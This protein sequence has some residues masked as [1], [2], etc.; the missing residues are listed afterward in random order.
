[1]LVVQGNFKTTAKMY[2]LCDI[3]R[4]LGWSRDIFT[5]LSLVWLL[6]GVLHNLYLV[7][8]LH[9]RWRQIG[10]TKIL[11]LTH[12][13]AS[14]ICIILH[15]YLPVN[16]SFNN[17]NSKQWNF[18]PALCAVLPALSSMTTSVSIITVTCIVLARY[19]KVVYGHKLTVVEAENAMLLSWC[20]GGFLGSPLLGLMRTEWE[21][22]HNVQ[23][24]TARWISNWHGDFYG[25][26][27]IVIQYIFPMVIMAAG[28]MKIF[29]HP[30]VDSRCC[31]VLF[32]VIDLLAAAA[33]LV[34]VL[35]LPLHVA[36]IGRGTE[37]SLLL[38]PKIFDILHFFE[39]LSICAFVS[40]PM[41]FI[42]FIEDEFHENSYQLLKAAV[43]RKEN[44]NGRDMQEPSGFEVICQKP[45]P[46]AVS[47]DL[48]RTS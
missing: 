28:L 20:I 23:I 43:K 29:V 35:F 11:I 44:Q 45:P 27:I 39:A 17:F 21:P 8:V 25:A 37:T 48:P 41:V 14:A 13:L 9:K 3:V 33:I 32:K 40:S 31:K 22:G 16:A 6:F 26:W 5:A 47:L 2:T 1:M 42:D 38:G 4:K 24:C 46:L 19:M 7:F 34:A 12:A 18:S 30:V 36:G 10:N 15:M